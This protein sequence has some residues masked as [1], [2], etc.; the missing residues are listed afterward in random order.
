MLLTPANL[1]IDGGRSGWEDTC[2]ATPR[3]LDI[4]DAGSIVL[5]TLKGS[6]GQVQVRC[7]RRRRAL[8]GHDLGRRDLDRL[9]LERPQSRGVPLQGR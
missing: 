4:I 5:Q 9:H 1:D 3:D 8:H 7:D 6:L 2:R